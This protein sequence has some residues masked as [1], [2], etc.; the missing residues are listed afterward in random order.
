MGL[1][2]EEADGGKVWIVD[3]GV[4]I[5]HRRA[6]NIAALEERDP[7]G[8][9]SGLQDV[10]DHAVEFIVMLRARSVVGQARVGAEFIEAV[11]RCK[12]P[13]PM[14][15]GINQRA[16]ITV[17]GRDTAGGSASSAVRSR[18]SPIGGSNERPPR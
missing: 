17:A 18:D 8:S 6:G 11:E 12:K 4:K 1:R 3:Q 7:F 16:D 2:L 14:L 10:G 9:R 15:V 13:L 5:V